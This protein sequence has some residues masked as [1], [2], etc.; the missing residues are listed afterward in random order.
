MSILKFEENAWKFFSK[1]G[2]IEGYLTYVVLK[3]LAKQEIS[4]EFGEDWVAENDTKVI[5]YSDKGD[6]GK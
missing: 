2:N 6:K 4:K 3:R 5:G 1:T